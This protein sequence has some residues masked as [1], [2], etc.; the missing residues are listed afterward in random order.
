MDLEHWLLCKY[1]RA[2]MNRE[3]CINRNITIASAII[4]GVNILTFY[5]AFYKCFKFKI[6]K[7]LLS[8]KRI[9]V[10]I[11]IIESLCFLIE[12]NRLSV[13]II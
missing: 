5:N 4:S 9:Y 7:V 3:K 13:M 1:R 2:A 11:Y 12:T 8:L 6:E 10:I